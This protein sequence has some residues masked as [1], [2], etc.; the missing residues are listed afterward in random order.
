MDKQRIRRE[1]AEKLGHVFIICQSGDPCTGNDNKRHVRYYH[2]PT[3]PDYFDREDDSA[4]LL[5][6]MP[7]PELWLESHKDEKFRLWACWADLDGSPEDGYAH[8]EDRRT[9]IV[10]AACK[11]KSVEVD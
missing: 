7:E 9:A 6:A 8:H 1:L 4:R 3:Y 10:L 2:K 11:W 5:E